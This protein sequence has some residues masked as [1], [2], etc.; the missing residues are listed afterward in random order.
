MATNIKN[1][2]DLER[3]KIKTI[4]GMKTIKL[5]QLTDD[6]TLFLKS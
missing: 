6:T 1:N 2:I 3:T 4:Y 5:T